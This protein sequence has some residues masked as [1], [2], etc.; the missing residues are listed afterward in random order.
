VGPSINAVEVQVQ[1]R[2]G[3]WNGGTALD[4]DLGSFLQML[5]DLQMLGGLL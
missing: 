3:R 4:L 1:A 5:K 2:G